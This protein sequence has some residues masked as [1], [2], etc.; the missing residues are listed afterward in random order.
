MKTFKQFI[1]EGNKSIVRDA[2][3]TAMIGSGLINA[4]GIPLESVPGIVHNYWQERIAP[5]KDQQINDLKRKYQKYVTRDDKGRRVLDIKSIPDADDRDNL[6]RLIAQH[7]E[8][9]T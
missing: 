9:H 3:A 7:E 4:T 5:T 1:T 2:L 8:N 6:E